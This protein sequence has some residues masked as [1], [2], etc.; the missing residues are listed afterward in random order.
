MMKFVAKKD[1]CT[2]CMLCE[3]ACSL[4]H[5]LMVNMDRARVQ[6]SH[7]QALDYKYRINVCRQCKV[8]PPIDACPVHAMNNSDVAL[9]AP[10]ESKTLTAVILA[11]VFNGDAFKLHL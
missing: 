11:K 2:G 6:I 1:L 8:C 4:S 9:R 7:G 5:D 3:S 10:R